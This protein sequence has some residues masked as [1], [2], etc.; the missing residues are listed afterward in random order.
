MERLTLELP[1]MYGDHH[2]VEVRSILAALPGIAKVY[3]SSARQK[4]EVEYDGGQLNAEAVKQALAARGYSSDSLDL[5]P[6]SPRTKTITEYAVGPG[7]VEE[8]VERVPAW[9]GAFGPCPGFE[10]LHPGDVHPADR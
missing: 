1:M 10:V 6:V 7:G 5:P 8:F 9:G 4:V 2:V 3:A